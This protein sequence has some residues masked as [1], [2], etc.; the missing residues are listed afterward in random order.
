MKKSI[1]LLLSLFIVVKVCAQTD[2]TQGQIKYEV[3]RKFEIKIQG[4]DAAQFQNMLPKERKSNKELIFN[5]DASLYQTI[6]SN[7]D[8]E[9]VHE[10][11]GGAV[12]IKMMEPNEIIYSDIKSKINL[13]QREFMTRNF[14]VETIT[15]TA[16]W[17]MTGNQKAILGFNC[18]E[19][20]LVGSKKKTIAW[21]TPMIPVSTGPDGYTGLPGLILLM[22]I[23]NGKTTYTAQNVDLKEIDP[24]LLK[25]PKDGKKVTRK[26]FNKIVEEKRKEMN[27][28]HGDGATVIIRTT[29]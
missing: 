14:L 28:G 12:M 17:K 2:N 24:S 3:V 4:G 1:V 9:A 22:D 23:D 26:E 27:M 11:Q 25:K 21:F 10:T 15:D 8:E 29:R 7:Q 6:N 20:E 13:E 16:Q 18:M 19:A 5:A